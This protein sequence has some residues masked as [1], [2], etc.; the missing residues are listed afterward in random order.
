MTTRWN[1]RKLINVLV[2]L[3]KKHQF[4]LRDIQRNAE[5][6]KQYNV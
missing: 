2:K 5:R 4:K 3:N 6:L 1:A